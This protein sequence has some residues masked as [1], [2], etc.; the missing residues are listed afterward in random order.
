MENAVLL[1]ERWIIA[2]LRHHRFQTL[3]DMNAAIG[4][5]VEKLNHR[6]F[7]K[8]E[9]CRASLFAELD[10]P[11]LQPLPAER[12]I[13]AHWKTVRASI[14]YHVEVDQHYYS[15]PYQLAGQSLEARFTAATVEIFHGG[16]RVASHARSSGRYRHTTV[17]EH[18]PKSHQAH[19][20]WTPSRLI[21]WAEGIGAATAEVVRRVL[22][23]KPHPEMGYRACLGIL[24]L[25]KTY[26]RA[27]LEAASQRA[28]QL[29]TCSYPSL[30]SILKRSLDQQLLLTS[31]VAPPGPQHENLRGPDYYDPPTTLVQ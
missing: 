10:R 21:R 20:E 25:E 29:Q 6:P 2:A 17:S 24:R 23:S 14:D 9:G 16:K 26:S 28:V 15:V 27:R 31:E 13:L 4:E 18:M 1:A 30:K 22:E 11:A 12:Y 7:R 8:R 5:L 19:L 3:A